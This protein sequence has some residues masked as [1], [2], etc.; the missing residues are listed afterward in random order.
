MLVEKD[1][2]FYNVVQVA[3]I[4]DITPDRLRTYDEYGLVMPARQANNRK[5]LYSEQDIEWLRDM[6]SVIGKNRM[7]LYALRIVVQLIR[8][9]PENSLE[10]LRKE[11][12][13]E[14]WE[15]LNRMRQNPNFSR[16]TGPTQNS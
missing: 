9:L 16:L 11:S 1:V 7:N 15:I 8:I 6:R 14:I 4:L 13:D 3:K 5:R 12:T 2:P 10:T